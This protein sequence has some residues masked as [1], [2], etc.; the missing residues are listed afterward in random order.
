MS[1]DSIT[2]EH[3][4]NHILQFFYCRFSAYLRWWLTCRLNSEITSWRWAKQTA[5]HILFSCNLYFPCRDSSCYE[6]RLSQKFQLKV[7]EKTSTSLL[8]SAFNMVSH[9]KYKL[10][11]ICLFKTNVTKSPLTN[12]FMK[13][14]HL[15]IL[16]VLSHVPALISS[17]IALSN[18]VII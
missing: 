7:K 6:H 8:N 13:K 16:R 9:R 3:Y 18:D 2:D 14:V 10:Q 5:K 12:K 1:R 11:D 4:I 15:S 17:Y